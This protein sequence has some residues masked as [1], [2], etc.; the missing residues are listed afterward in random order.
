MDSYQLH[1]ALCHHPACNG[2][3]YSAGDEQSR[4][5]RRARGHTA[6]AFELVAVNKRA[7]VAHLDVY[8][9]IGV[10][11]IDFQMV[12]FRE[13]LS[14]DLSAYRGRIER[15]LL[16]RALCLDLESRCGV[17]QGSRIFNAGVENNV[18]ILFD[19][20]GAR[21][22]GYAED[23][24]KS[25]GRFVEIGI[26]GSFDY[27]RRLRGGAGEFA[28]RRESA[29]DIRHEHIFKSAPVESLECKL[30][31]FD[32][33]NFLHV[34]IPFLFIL[35]IFSYCFLPLGNAVDEHVYLFF[36]GKTREADSER[37]LSDFVAQPHIFEHRALMSL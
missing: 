7:L 35:L 15:K 18:H 16:V 30:T 20:G 11:N 26:L 6:R 32:E 8:Y 21:E 1:A 10:M 9:N 33:N 19:C 34:V 22:S 25:F 13:Y 14:A 28:E 23:L 24:E 31:V 12:E 3:V 2:A 36:C 27:Y 5:S 37:A 17:E 4:L 29:T